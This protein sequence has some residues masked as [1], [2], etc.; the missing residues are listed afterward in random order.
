MIEVKTADKVQ[1]GER[2][3]IRR[4]EAF[5]NV[6]EVNEVAGGT[7]IEIL[8]DGLRLPW[9]QRDAEVTVYYPGDP[10]FR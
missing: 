8:T 1:V 9:L 6:T 7:G 4:G 10:M 5:A 3:C 2:V